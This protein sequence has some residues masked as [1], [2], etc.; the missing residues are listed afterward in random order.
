MK[1]NIFIMAVLAASLSA[2]TDRFQLVEGQESGEIEKAQISAFIID[3]ETKT[4]LG[5]E[6]TDGYPVLWSA[7]DKIALISEEI[8][9]F[10]IDP[11]DVPNQTGAGH[12]NATF[13]GDAS[14]LAGIF[15]GSKGYPAVYPVEGAK[16]RYENGQILVGTYL[17]IK[18][19]YKEGSFGENVFPMSAV[20][21]TGAQYDFLN[22]CGVLRFKIRATEAGQ[23]IKA[24]Y[25]SGKSGETVAGGIGMW[26]NAR[27]CEPVEAADGDPVWYNGYK[28]ETFGDEGY[29]KI[30]MD[31]GATPIEFASVGEEKEINIAVIPQTFSYGI[32]LELV[33]GRNNGISV[34][35][36]HSSDEN[37]A[38]T[39]KRG[40][41][42]EMATI[43]YV[44]P[45]EIQIANS[46]IYSEPGY[47]LMPAYAM[48][49]RMDVFLDPHNEHPN[50]AA[51]LLWT[52]LVD[53]SG[54]PLPAVT[55]IEYLPFDDGKG[56]IQFKIN[57]DP[58]TH[59]AYRGN[60]AIALYDT[61]TKE[62]LWSWHIWM[63]EEV[64]DTVTGGYCAAGTYSYTLPDGTTV[65]NAAEATKDKL[66][67]MDRNLGAI[68]AN[69]AD[70]WKTYGLFYQN[71]R[72]DP[73]IG[74][75]VNGSNANTPLTSFNSGKKDNIS[76]RLDEPDPFVTEDA[77]PSNPS[78]ALTARTWW[79]RD[80]APLGW[81]YYVGYQT[82]SKALANPLTYS[83]AYELTGHALS[84][85]GQWTYYLAT[86]NKEWMDP[87]LGY[88]TGIHGST[89]LSDGGHQSY[90]N[91]TKT[92]MDPCP[93]GYSVL[94]DNASYFGKETKSFVSSATDGYGMTT[95]FTL[96]GVT[97]DTWWPAAGCRS[98]TGKLGS[99][100]YM[101]VY[102][103]YDHISATHGGHGFYFYTTATGSGKF[104]TQT[105]NHGGSLR[106]V[107]E[108][109]FVDLTKYPIKRP[110]T[111][112]E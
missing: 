78:R 107:R 80:L 22:L 6:T 111:T 16:A 9:T 12:P 85:N 77:D 93:V 20:S 72:R 99:V 8:S 83:T 15:P 112:S 101:G 92:V 31:F 33:D 57:V 18:Q 91:R 54:N 84:E 58:D 39:V 7:N 66:I 52:D 103:H 64:Y 21:K 36:G 88:T 108:K 44:K 60:A 51:A 37:M 73:F 76:V 40:M 41:I 19:S 13:S 5:S 24:I 98:I 105:T 53:A 55:N 26:Y 34:I 62:I 79:N 94:G 89:G 48:G 102:Y 25:L 95:S 74:A 4:S 47:Y 11:E 90:W 100:G 70:G 14:A 45:T 28:V 59:E 106:C 69:P 96:S 46:Y 1:Y 32:K 82:V 49:N 109:Q 42:K 27:S 65:D 61:D 81:N 63:C 56:Q 67:I 38:L 97:Y 71:G 50:K 17:P 43:E 75:H 2:C 68:S 86:D 104:E 29:Q 30:I 23:K 110:A 35:Y 3:G 10:T 87:S